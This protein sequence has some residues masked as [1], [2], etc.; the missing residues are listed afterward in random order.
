MSVIDQ[1]SARRFRSRHQLL[2][3]I[4][5]ENGVTR[6]DLSLITGLSRSAIAD[7]VADLLNDR[8]I[9]ES[10]L[11]PPG[12]GAG[13]GRP[14]A[15]LIPTEQADG[16]VV[17]IDLGHGHVAVAVADT[18]G[19][20]LAEQRVSAD[21]DGQAHSTLDTLAGVVSRLLVQTD[22]SLADVR[23]ISA[24]IPA[25]IDARTGTILSDTI[26]RGWKGLNP[27]DEL[28]D[29]FGR[30]VSVANDADMGAQGEM[31]YGAAR[32]I[33][34]FVYVKASTGIGASVVVNGAV[35]RGARGLAGEI[36]HTRL[37]DQGMWCRCGNRGC[38]ETVVSSDVVLERMA[39][40]SIVP[41]DPV[42]PLRDAASSAVVGASVSEAGRTLGRVLADFCNW[43]NPSAIILGGELGTAGQLMVD[44]VRESV[45]RF[46][47]P[48]A[49]AE[50]EVRAAQFGLRSE[51]IGAIATANH[52][53]LQLT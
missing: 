7:G 21:V 48:G 13:R 25:P 50:L 24:A 6:A 10:V 38:L 29:L 5:R 39:E 34:D 8:L 45:L 49:V 3:V 22:R 33:R 42:F 41:A 36:G 27:A 19:T 28:S 30:R 23:A 20:A 1:S 43:L 2:D 4:R 37:S 18:K 9:A 32:G 11:E 17:G 51:L 52:E 12:K 15:L 16:V 14:S 26:M 40:A 46:A 47:Q 35:Y 31:R 53:A 44:G